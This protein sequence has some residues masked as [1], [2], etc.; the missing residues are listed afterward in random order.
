MAM[1]SWLLAYLVVFSDFANKGA[2]SFV[3]VDAL[4]G[5]RLNEFAPKV[6]GKITALC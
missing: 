2:K 3:H 1:M 5:R 6:L 4:L